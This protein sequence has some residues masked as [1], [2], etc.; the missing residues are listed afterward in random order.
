MRVAQR[1]RQGKPSRSSRPQETDDSA[2][3]A[4][5]ENLD[6]AAT[7]STTYDVPL[8]GDKACTRDIAE[9]IIA[10]RA[11]V[12]WVDGSAGGNDYKDGVLG[13]GVLWHAGNYEYTRSYQLG[14][15]T[16]ESA[17]AEL[18][19]LAAALGL[20]KQEVEKEEEEGVRRL[21][22]IRV[23]TDAKN[24]LDSIVAWTCLTLGPLISPRTAL[25]SLFEC[26]E[27]LRDNGVEVELHWVKGHANSDGN[28][29]ADRS[30]TEAV[31]AQAEVFARARTSRREMRD[32]DV[33]DMFKEIDDDWVDEWL[34]RANRGYEAPAQAPCPAPSSYTQ[35][36]DH[37]PSLE[38]QYR[39]P[40]APENDA[41]AASPQKTTLITTSA[42]RI[43][44][45]PSS[46]TSILKSVSSANRC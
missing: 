7:I 46:N 10:G 34:Y 28:E 17:D 16:G 13:A 38:T 23:Y 43:T 18:Y 22:L 26:A 4:T 27:W 44:C 15:Y 1:R 40:P 29:L 21:A 36:P 30:A 35:N 24:V 12:Y 39:V 9:D 8:E 20:A 41:D 6:L 31:T 3:C 42:Q 45:S 5:I 14:R 2:V 19:A 32:E 33:P 11:I 25:Q 37:S